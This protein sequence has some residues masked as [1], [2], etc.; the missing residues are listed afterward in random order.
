MAREGVPMT[1]TVPRLAPVVAAVWPAAAEAGA[2][3]ANLGVE[4]TVDDA[5]RLALAAG[6]AAVEDTPSS[7]ERDWAECGALAVTGWPDRTPLHPVGRPATVARAAGLAFELLSGTRIDGAALLGERAAIMGLRR[8]GQISAG[9]GTRLL[10]ASDNWWALNLA[11]DLDLVPALIEA[12]VAED[13][14]KRVSEWAARRPVTAIIERTQ[15]LGLA[16]AALGETPKPSSPW[17]IEPFGPGSNGRRTPVVVNFGA[18]WAAPLAAHLLAMIGARVVDVES[19]ERPDPTRVTSS[20][21]YRRLHA[22]HEQ[23]RVD[24]AD[25]AQLRDLIAAADVVIEASRPRAFEALGLDA[26]TILAS[27]RPRIWLRITGHRD[28]D[29]VA[30]GDDAAVA[31]GLVAWESGEPVFAGD[32][33]ADPLTGVLA[34]VAVAACLRTDASCLIEMSLADVAAY[35]AR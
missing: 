25:P 35:C 2:L 26:R 20:E 31:G 28:S 10:R 30:F 13:P 1:A 33:I 14:W 8:A 6:G 19:T 15:L 11:R 17:R 18:L 27:G 24:F 3:L 5:A 34:A 22:G 32:A 4:V 16:A 9:G 12:E 29:R 23:R 21:F 7:E